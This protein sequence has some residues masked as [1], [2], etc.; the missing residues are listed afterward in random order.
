MAKF[1]GVVKNCECCGKEFKVPKSQERVRTCSK[2]CGYKIRVVANK[3]EWVTCTCK[4]CGGVF[5]APP[6]QAVDRVYCSNECRFASTEYRANA[7]NRV[8]GAAN[9]MWRG[10]AAQQVVSSTGKQYYRSSKVVEYAR[11]SRRSTQKRLA[12]PGWADQSIMRELRRAARALTR[13]TGVQHHVDHI[14]PLQHPLVC[15]LHC[16]ANLRIV[17]ATDNIAKSNRSEI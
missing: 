2:E 9:P 7:A 1:K 10:G 3:V 11:T 8:T 15:G 6:S 13:Q 17:S 16:E 12:T 4:S 14:I 5:Q